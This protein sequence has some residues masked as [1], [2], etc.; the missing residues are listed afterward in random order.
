MNITKGAS[1][2]ACDS[3]CFPLSPELHRLH[4]QGGVPRAE[5]WKRE[6]EYVDA[7]R[8]ALIQKGQW[9]AEV[10]LHY[11]TSLCRPAGRRSAHTFS[12]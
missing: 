4:D 10:E 3:L 12:M 9:P 11:G 7:T 6:C 5:R 1:L 2:K 8:A